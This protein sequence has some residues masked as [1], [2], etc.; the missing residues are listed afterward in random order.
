MSDVMQLQTNAESETFLTLA[1]TVPPVSQTW[2]EQILA[3][4][5]TIESRQL[6]DVQ[7]TSS[8]CMIL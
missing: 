7:P 4:F 2:R 3:T 6:T 5:E 1:I 8:G